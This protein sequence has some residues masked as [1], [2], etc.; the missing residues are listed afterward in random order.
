MD[1]QALPCVQRSLEHTGL[2]RNLFTFYLLIHFFIK[3]GKNKFENSR[4]FRLIPKTESV[5]VLVVMETS[6]CHCPAATIFS[7]Q[8]PI[9]PSPLEVTRS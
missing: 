8:G 5:S 1:E 6:T 7:V 2:N 3:L 9:H 4:Q